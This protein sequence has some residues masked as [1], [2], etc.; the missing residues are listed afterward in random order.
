M[1]AGGA[2]LKQYKRAPGVSIRVAFKLL[3]DRRV[4]LTKTVESKCQAVAATST[5]SILNHLLRAD[6]QGRGS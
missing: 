4:L 2:T 5:A 6:K 1:T 3:R